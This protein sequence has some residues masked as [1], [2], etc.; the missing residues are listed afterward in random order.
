MTVIQTHIQWRTSRGLTE[1][2]RFI[3]RDFE[4]EL[5]R[6]AQTSGTL[7]ATG[8]E[9]KGYTHFVLN[10]SRMEQSLDTVFDYRSS[11]GYAIRLWLEIQSL[12]ER[13]IGR[14]N[15]SDEADIRRTVAVGKM[16]LKKGRDILIL[17][18][19]QNATALEQARAGIYAAHGTT[20]MSQKILDSIARAAIETVKD[21]NP[22]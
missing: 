8:I 14:F 7:A 10:R 17:Q 16:F 5:A 22:I 18:M 2:T 20:E 15:S 11:D 6:F 13:E 19:K 1:A 3:L 4:N 21:F 9:C 12:L